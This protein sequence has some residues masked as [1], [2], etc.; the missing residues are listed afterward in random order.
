MRTRV[1][2]VN[3]FSKHN[4]GY[5]K[6]GFEVLKRLSA[7]KDIRI[8]ELACYASEYNEKNVAQANQLPWDVYFNVPNM[9]NPEHANAYKSCK[10]FEYGLFKF[11]DALLHFKPHIVMDIRDFW[12]HEYQETSPFRDMY[13]W[14]IMTTVDARPQHE[15]WI[16]TFSNADGVFTYTDWGMDVLKEQTGDNI[17]L[18]G[19]ASPAADKCYCPVNKNVAKSNI[20]I[21]P[22]AKIIG[23]VMRNQGRKLFPDL[24]K[25]FRDYIRQTKRYDTYLYCH[26]AYPDV[27]WDIPDLLKKYEIAS[28]VL[29]TY[30]CVDCGHVYPTFYQGM[31]TACPRCNRLSSKMPRVN[32]GVT[33]EQLASIIQSFDLYVQYMSNEGFGMPVV[34]A[35]QCG[36]PVVAVGY[37]SMEDVVPK[38]GGDMVS[39]A[40]LTTEPQTG[41]LRAIPDNK[42][43]TE[44]LVDFFSLPLPNRAIKS[45]NTIEQTYK[46]YSW[47]DTAN[48]WYNH[49]KTID[50]QK[51]EQA[52]QT[53]SR[54]RMPAPYTN[55]QQSMTNM[56]FCIWLIT[57]VLCDPSKLYGYMHM[58]L[59]RD[60]NNG[61][62]LTYGNSPNYFSEDSIADKKAD[63]KTFTREDAY[64]EVLDLCNNFNGWE[65]KRIGGNYATIN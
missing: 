5:S 63:I 35:G 13:N 23:T 44:Y 2:F 40:A 47:D 27:A 8:A 43:F 4:S 62:V 22:D 32:D 46:N 55:V 29:F 58:R 10:A 1:L 36:I 24:F 50:I 11:N 52:W 39:P 49:F 9:N 65:A 60:V 53:P 21:S 56:D 26:T 45:K 57:Q 38:V 41:R 17:N 16:Y 64:K 7:R 25:A 12:M 33:D 6:Y 48:K 20:G 18:L 42:A 30:K 61:F 51:Y 54:I 31:G 34:E 37:S 15:Q 28:R 59:L 14:T 19:S 3:E